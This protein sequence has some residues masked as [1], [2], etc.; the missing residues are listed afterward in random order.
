MNHRPLWTGLARTVRAVLAAARGRDGPELATLREQRL[1]SVAVPGTEA[2][3]TSTHPAGTALGKPRY[4]KLLRQLP[5][6]PGADPAAVLADAVRLARDDHWIVPTEPPTVGS[7]V[8]DKTVHHAR[9]QAGISVQDIDGRPILVINLT[10]H[11]GAT[12]T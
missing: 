3:T 12:V 4:A 10:H 8:L 5:L 2:G 9:L 6:E 1:A 7:W 11:G